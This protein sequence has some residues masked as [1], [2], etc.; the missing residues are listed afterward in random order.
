MAKRESD[1]QP[2]DVR[3]VPPAADI[4]VTKVTALTTGTRPKS[5]DEVRSSVHPWKPLGAKGKKGKGKG[6][7]K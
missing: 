2:R 6:K 1:R 5:P 3:V 4:K 7:K